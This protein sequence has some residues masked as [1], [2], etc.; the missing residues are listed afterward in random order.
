MEN[1]PPKQNL[2]IGFLMTT[3]PEHQNCHT[4]VQLAETFIAAGNKV[5]LF[6]MDDGVYNIVKGSFS[7]APRLETL[8]QK[9]M[10]ISLCTQSAEGRG[11]SAKE[12][13]PGVQ[14]LSQHELSGIVARSDRFLIF[15]N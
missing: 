12:G 11:V 1:A 3:S 13:L 4:V 14:W 6:L 9:G 15:G 10:T 8:L 7:Y 5:E 2:S